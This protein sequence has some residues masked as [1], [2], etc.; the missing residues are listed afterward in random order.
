MENYKFYCILILIM[1]I[2][3]TEHWLNQQQI[4]SMKFDNFSVTSKF[5]RMNDR[6]GSFIYV[7]REI[8]TK[9]LND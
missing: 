7:K 3:F 4:E 8:R 6:G 2:C 9:E 5:C 1:L